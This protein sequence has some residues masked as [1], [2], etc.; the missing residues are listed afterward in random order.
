MYPIFDGIS[1]WDILHILRAYEEIS[2]GYERRYKQHLKFGA[3]PFAHNEHRVA[4]TYFLEGIIERLNVETNPDFS[5]LRHPRMQMGKDLTDYLDK[6]THYE[7][8]R[9]ESEFD[10]N[11]KTF[12]N[13][14]PWGFGGYFM[15]REKVIY[16]LVNSAIAFFTNGWVNRTDKLHLNASLKPFIQL[17]YPYDINKLVPDE[18]LKLQVHHSSAQ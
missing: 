9:Q 2:G 10:E 16:A 1:Q 17:G 3:G 5:N 7:L 14:E 8:R 15:V 13:R 11:T 6:E 18:L 4:P 12:R